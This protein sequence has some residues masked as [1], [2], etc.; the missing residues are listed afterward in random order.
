VLIEGSSR[1]RSWRRKELVIN[2][3]FEII[4]WENIRRRSKF[5][6]FSHATTC[7]TFYDYYVYL[8][9]LLCSLILELHNISPFRKK[10][11][12]PLKNLLWVTKYTWKTTIPLMCEK[13]TT[14]FKLAN[15]YKH[16]QK[17]L[18]EQGSW[19]LEGLDLFGGACSKSWVV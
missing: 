9:N 19:T 14:I 1:M 17:S 5:K 4:S 7:Q 2:V 8:F 15:G 11:Y 10:Y 12:Q 16:A 3:T 18:W 6:G 13:I